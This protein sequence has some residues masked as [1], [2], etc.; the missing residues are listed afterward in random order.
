MA[1]PTAP[2]PLQV[3]PAPTFRPRFP[4]LGGDLQTLRNYLLRRRADLS[5]W[6]GRRLLLAMSDRSGDRLS[7]C[8][9]R[10][11]ADRDHRGPGAAAS[12]IL[13]HGLTGCE[14]SSYVR[15]SARALL[16]AGHAVL[17]LNLRGAGPSRATCRLGYH[18]GRSEDLADV[19]DA[20][21]E[22]EPGFCAPGVVP[23]GFS[24]GA[25]VLIKLLGE[26]GGEA[27]GPPGLLRGAVSVSSP[28]DLEAAQHR[29]MA[30]RNA[31]Y[32]RYLLAR[33]KA[34]AL[35]PPAA[36]SEAERRAIA[37]A[38]DVLELDDRYVAPR[39]GFAGAAD[40]YARCSA[41]RFLR[42]VGLP[43]LVIQALDDPWIPAAAYRAVDWG[44]NP[45]LVPAI[46]ERGGHVGFHGA[47]P[48]IAW[49]DARI[50]AFLGDLRRAGR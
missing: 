21:A 32:Q 50:V 44:A 22:L 2:R 40:Y 4:W 11:L 39:N 10:P 49:H 28:L 13:I 36:A 7:A 42:A 46:A 41:G 20:L 18:A 48:E 12:V 33:M 37:A 35:A 29:L 24:L 30:P 23:V 17:R 47:D 8:L 6:P 1:E 38:R 25:N 31:L 16:A 5:A 26:Q 14:D 43:L 45:R 15:A 27:P 34:E 19:L 3:S 9:H